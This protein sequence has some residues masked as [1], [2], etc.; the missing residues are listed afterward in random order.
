[1]TRVVVKSKAVK[2]SKAK[3]AAKATKA[4]A[5]KAAAK[6]TTKRDTAKASVDAQ[7]KE[8]AKLV[9]QG[10]KMGDIAEK[11]HVTAGRAKYL[12]MLNEVESGAVP[13]ISTSGNE[14]AIAKRIIAARNKQDAYSS[15]G[16]IS[17][18]TGLPEVKVK[19]LAE[20]HGLKVAGTHVAKERAASKPAGKPAK[21]K[22]AKTTKAKKAN[23][24]K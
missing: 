1:M 4:K 3:P 17:A 13:S 22:A 20:E 5:T 9:K 14:E 16:Y 18:R 24:S 15:W 12:Q 11:L 19:K 23:P 8:V 21:A 6:A 10:V 7:R 2:V